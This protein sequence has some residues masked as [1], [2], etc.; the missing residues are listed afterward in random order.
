MKDGICPKCG[1]HEVY[2]ADKGSHR[3]GMAIGIMR[4]ARV[5][6]YVCADC[7]YVEQ[8]ILNTSSLELIRQKWERADGQPN[9]KRKR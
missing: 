3:N 7:G 4:S 5:Q 1:S 9:E 8:Y 6:D 2:T